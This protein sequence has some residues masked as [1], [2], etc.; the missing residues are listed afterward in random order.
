MSDSVQTK[1]FPHYR[2]KSDLITF[3]SAIEIASELIASKELFILFGINALP[4]SSD[5]HMEKKIFSEKY[6]NIT[7]EMFLEI[8]NEE[9]VMLAGRTLLN[10]DKDGGLRD[11]LE[12][13]V[14][15]EVEIKRHV[16]GYHQK[17]SSVK[18]YIINDKQKNWHALKSETSN[19][20]ILYFSH[21]ICKY[22]LK[23][24]GDIPFVHIHIAANE[25][26]IYSDSHRY[27]YA[28]VAGNADKVSFV[29]DTNDLECMI[30]ILS[31]IKDK[32]EKVDK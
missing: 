29:C 1:T 11:W 22:M 13:F 5:L 4:V 32:L 31:N 15:D 16:E 24:G 21:D 9:I 28:R 14:D 2:Y 20:K 23:N 17:L 8:L 3:N 18:K 26:I 6:K 10:L 25:E 7:H 27:E 19:K 30:K 12:E